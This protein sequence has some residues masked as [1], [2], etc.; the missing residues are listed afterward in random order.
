MSL[1]GL[2]THCVEGGRKEWESTRP[3]CLSDQRTGP[4]RDGVEGRSPGHLTGASCSAGRQHCRVHCPR[5]LVTVERAGEEDSIPGQHGG[6]RGSRGCGAVRIIGLQ[7]SRPRRNLQ[8]V[9][10]G[11]AI[12]TRL[13][14]ETSAVWGTEARR[15]ALRC[16]GAQTTGHPGHHEVQKI[17]HSPDLPEVGLACCGHFLG[18]RLTARH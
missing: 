8:G 15:D 11:R 16:S 7:R 6:E 13:P 5:E 4:L 18:V 9:H 10:G 2:S 14:P 17:A 1:P 3:S 12:G